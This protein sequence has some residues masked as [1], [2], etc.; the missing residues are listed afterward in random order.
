MRDLKGVV[1]GTIVPISLV[2]DGNTN[3]FNLPN[4]AILVLAHSIP[5]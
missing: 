2:F 5:W 1:V 4:D 3:V